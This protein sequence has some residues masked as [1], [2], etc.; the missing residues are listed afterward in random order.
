MTKKHSS[1]KKQKVVHTRVPEELFDS[2]MEKAKKHRTTASGFIRNF[3]EDFLEI[4]EDLSD[5]SAE[6]MRSLLFGEK[7]D[8][9]VGHQEI[10]LAKDTSCEK[11]EKKL[12]KGTKAK[13][14]F[15]EGTT[16]SILVCAKCCTKIENSK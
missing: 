16:R 7:E 15:L 14:L 10:S 2:I 12:S 4:S 6:K 5:L 13:I 11:C 8:A 3:L 9:V 1:T